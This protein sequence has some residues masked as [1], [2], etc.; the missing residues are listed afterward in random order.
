MKRFG[1]PEEVANAILFLASDDSSYITGAEIIV[2]GGT[3]ASDSL[4]N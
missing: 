2:D 1:K 4:R 3:S